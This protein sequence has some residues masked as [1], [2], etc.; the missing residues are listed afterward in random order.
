MH[1]S[2]A[3]AS[4][5]SG[6]LTIYNL[7]IVAQ[8]RQTAAYLD[9]ILKG[10]KPADLPVQQPTKFQHVIN[11][12]TAKALGLAVPLTMQASADEVIE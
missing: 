4:A 9:R 11:L 3:F 8:F 1:H 5:R 6:G 7:D 12:K 10:E 2:N